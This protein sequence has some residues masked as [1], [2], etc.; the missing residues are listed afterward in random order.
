M[1][2]SF[3]NLGQCLT[4]FPVR[5]PLSSTSLK[6]SKNRIFVSWPRES[7]LLRVLRMHAERL[8]QTKSSNFHK[9]LRIPQAFRKTR[10]LGESLFQKGAYISLF[11]S[12]LSF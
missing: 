10:D 12:L 6:N 1:W 3:G 9:S 7:A 8:P 5:H 4:L 2:F 11:F